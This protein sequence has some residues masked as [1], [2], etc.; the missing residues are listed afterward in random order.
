VI[1]KEQSEKWIEGLKNRK[2][3][4]VK[5]GTLSTYRSLLSKWILP[6]LADVDISTFGNSGLKAFATSLAGKLA[7]KSVNEIVAAVKQ[8]VASAVDE[9]GDQLHL[10]K[11]NNVFIDLPEVKNQKTPTISKQELSRVIKESEPLHGLFVTFLAGTGLRIGEARA[12]RIGDDGVHSAWDPETRLI[13]VRTA[14]WRGIEQTPKTD[15]GIRQIDISEKL[16]RLLL[17]QTSQKG[18]TAGDE[19]LFTNGKG[20]PATESTLR[21]TILK[22]FGIKGFHC[23]R[24]F[25]VTHLREHI[26][27]PEDL[28]KFWVGHAG[29]GITDRYSYLKVN[30]ELRKSWAERAGLGFETEIGRHS[31]VHRDPQ[32]PAY[33][34]QNGSA[35]Q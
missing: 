2:R 25:R 30:I 29:R 32:T 23:F 8:I 28:I 27:V 15:A 9:N 6:S 11:W 1:F 20:N 26:G 16:N 19:F 31:T 14:F 17:D 18:Y 7:P 24:R 10:R 12:V 33:V 13:W 21:K 34:E 5:P 3:R 4:V 35:A 22:K